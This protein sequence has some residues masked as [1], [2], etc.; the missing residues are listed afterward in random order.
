MEVKAKTREFQR[1]LQ[2]LGLSQRLLQRESNRMGMHPERVVAGVR[3]LVTLTFKI[4]YLD[5]H[6][7]SRV[8]LSVRLI[9]ELLL[10][11][12]GCT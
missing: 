2:H 4:C 11:L 1:L 12:V 8:Y 5:D 10:L 3:T 7:T 9:V 6:D